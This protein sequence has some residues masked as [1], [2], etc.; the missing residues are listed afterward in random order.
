VRLP[1]IQDATI[2]SLRNR[3]ATGLPVLLDRGLNRGARRDEHRRAGG[4]QRAKKGE[5]LLA[6]RDPIPLA[7]EEA[8]GLILEI[9]IRRCRRI[10]L[11]VELLDLLGNVRNHGNERGDQRRKR[12]AT[13][14]RVQGGAK[15]A[16]PEVEPIEH[17]RIA[18]GTIELKH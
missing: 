2:R 10:R 4:S 11:D 9:R 7:L 14:A 8:E 16:K 17:L 3:V 1:K 15:K 12:A 18:S 13:D 5:G 6:R